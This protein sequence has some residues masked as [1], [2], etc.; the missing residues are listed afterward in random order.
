MRTEGWW[1]DCR[2]KSRMWRIEHKTD[3]SGFKQNVG[4]GSQTDILGDS[5]GCLSGSKLE[6][7]DIAASDLLNSPIVQ[8]V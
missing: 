3:G 8:N 4:C 6:H 2:A 5:E 1:E 7:T